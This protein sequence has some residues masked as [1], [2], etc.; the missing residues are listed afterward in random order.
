MIHEV[1]TGQQS[2]RQVPSGAAVTSLD[3][4]R[5]KTDVLSSISFVFGGV[6][7]G[8]FDV[9]VPYTRG[10]PFVLYFVPQH[11]DSLGEISG[12][13]DCLVTDG[14]LLDADADMAQ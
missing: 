6:H 1:A 8:T 3:A 7:F 5:R 12:P 13:V 10:K 9:W 14:E 2:A 4:R 11:D